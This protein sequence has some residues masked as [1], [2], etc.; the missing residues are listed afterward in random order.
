M[1]GVL[2]EQNAHLKADIKFNN[3]AHHMTL[4]MS[5]AST[6]NQ[7]GGGGVIEHMEGGY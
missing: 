1:G 3:G 4:N 2:R 7:K 6:K 5:F